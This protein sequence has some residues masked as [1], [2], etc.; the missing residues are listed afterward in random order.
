MGRI[1]LGQ[2][3][4][5]IGIQG[6][7]H[8]IACSIAATTGVERWYV[9]GSRGGAG[10]LVNTESQVD[11][12]RYRVTRNEF[13]YLGCPTGVLH[14]TVRH[15]AEGQRTRG[16]GSRGTNRT[17]SYVAWRC[18][19]VVGTGPETT[20]SPEVVH[21]RS[22]VGRSD[23]RRT[24]GGTVPH[25]QGIEAGFCLELR[26]HSLHLR[27]GRGRLETDGRVNVVVVR[28]VETRRATGI[29]VGQKTYCR[30]VKNGLCAR[31]V[32]VVLGR[33]HAG[34]AQQPQHQRA[35]DRKFLV[36]HGINLKF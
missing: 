27:T 16:V 21:Y 22:T 6:I 9:Q 26:K 10:A 8:G 20:R 30:H 1:R 17:G 3:G 7:A 35:D 33:D 18:S 29:V 11:R 24:R 28:R 15:E 32:R 12:V 2:A 36:H 5:R 4:V 23:L 31:V 34:Q 25:I 13:R 14:A 19:R